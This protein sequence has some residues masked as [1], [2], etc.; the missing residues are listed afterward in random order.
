M[1]HHAVHGGQAKP[2]RAIYR[3][4]TISQPFAALIADGEKWVE[5]RTWGTTLAI[6]AG[7][8]T[9]YMTRRQLR[10]YTT[11]AVVAVADLVAVFR[12]SYLQECN[13]EM[14]FLDTRL[15]VGEILDHEHT[16]GPFC[17]L[18]RNVRKLREPVKRGGMMGLWFWA[19]PWGESEAATR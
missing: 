10:G 8:G 19:A 1:M 2:K 6:H 16:E 12:L 3:A 4:L 17:W 7:S 13:R 18:L 5:N 11:G 14:R 9:Q 15:T